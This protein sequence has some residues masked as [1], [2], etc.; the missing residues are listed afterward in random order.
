MA[1]RK[2]NGKDIL[3]FIDPTGSTSYKTVVCLTSNSLNRTT[4]TESAAS[5]CGPDIA[6]GDQTITVPFAGQIVYEAEATELASQSLHSLWQNSTTIGWKQSPATP[7][8]GDVTYSGTGWISELVETFDA[9]GR[10]TFTGTIS[11]IG[12]VTQTVTES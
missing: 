11:V 8:D 2:I 5:K 7:K 9:T 12:N 3:L 6:P 4:G 1:K 10:A